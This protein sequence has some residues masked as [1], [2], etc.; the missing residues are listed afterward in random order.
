MMGV[1]TAEEVE[2]LWARLDDEAQAVKLSHQAVLRFEQF[3]RGLSD[4]DR[5]VVDGVL[6]NWI[7]RGLDSRRRFDGLAVI[8]RFEIRSALPALREAVSALDCAEG[9]SV[10]FERSKLGRIIEKIEAAGSSCVS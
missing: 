6:A 10:P 1:L 7:G 4:P 8:S 2:R 5:S 9:P 3:Y